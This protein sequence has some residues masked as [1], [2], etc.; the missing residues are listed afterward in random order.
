MDSLFWHL[1][2]LRPILF[3]I[4]AS[5]TYLVKTL[6]FHFIDKPRKHKLPPGPKPW[7]I[8]GNLPEMLVNKPVAKWIHSLMNDMHKEIACIKFGSI[9]VIV[10]TNPTIA[11]EFL[12]AQD[13][14]FA[15]RPISMSTDIVSRGYL[16]TVL[17]PYGEQWKKMKKVLV[18]ELLSPHKHQWLHDKRIGE[19]D[20]LVRYVFNQC[21]DPNRGG[22]VNARITA[23]HYCGNVI[24]Q[25]LFSTRYFGQNMKDGGPGI[26]EVQH[27]EATFMLLKYIYAF[28]VSDFIPCLRRLD[29]DGHKK[30][31][32]KAMAMLEKYHDPIV[33][34]RIEQW[35][36]G[37]KSTEEDLFDVLIALKDHNGNSLLTTEEI[38]AQL[39]EFMIEVVDNPSNAVEWAIAEML[40]KP[41]LLEKATEEIDEVV[42]KERLV[43]ESH[44]PKLNYV[45]ACARVFTPL[46]L[47]MFLR[48]AL[49]RNPKVWDEP[50]KF[51]Q[52]VILR[53]M[54]LKLL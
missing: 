35:K 50:H 16:T 4:P 44:L 41:E 11:C 38:K 31:V 28:C 10:V 46:C 2:S 36:N 42:G 52:N 47:S 13:A 26:E 30:M 37:T 7:P 25:M 21:N 34:E 22:L 29:L 51:N 33:H 43:Q 15:S 5:F 8:V 1:S 12:K 6:N 54:D 40:N 48:Q 45:K 39:I 24:R 27:L 3:L 9:H 19:A 32:K 14:V 17:V 49:G 20:N 18:K 23:Q 53:V